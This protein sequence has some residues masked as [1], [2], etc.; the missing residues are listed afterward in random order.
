MCDVRISPLL[1]AVIEHPFS[2]DLCFWQTVQ[3]NGAQCLRRFGTAILHPFPKKGSEAGLVKGQ[4]I[5][6]G[7]FVCDAALL[8]MGFYNA[9]P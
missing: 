5:Q 8:A 4:I 6:H 7:P 3:Q 9:F 1:V 2:E